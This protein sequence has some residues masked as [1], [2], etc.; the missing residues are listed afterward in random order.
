MQRFAITPTDKAKIGIID[1]LIAFD[2]LYEVG[3]NLNF[4]ANNNKL[5][6]QIR[7]MGWKPQLQK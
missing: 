7:M 5:T 1:D 2:E 4:E 3:N 6:L